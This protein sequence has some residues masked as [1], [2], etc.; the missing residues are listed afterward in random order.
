MFDRKKNTTIKNLSTILEKMERIYQI[1]DLHSLL[2]NIL[3]ETRDFTRADAGS[4]FLVNNN[5]LKFSFVQND[6]LYKNDILSNKYIYANREI[7]INEKSIAGYVAL[8]G[9]SLIIDDAYKLEG[10]EPYSFIHIL[11][12]CHFT[13]RNLCL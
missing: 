5:K 13:K 7:E 12:L 3:T 9:E 6:T 10:K 1:K 8:T 11:I 2:D 4:I